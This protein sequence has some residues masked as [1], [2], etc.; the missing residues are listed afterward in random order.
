MVR[1][2]LLSGLLTVSDFSSR[3]DSDTSEAQLSGLRGPSRQ[4]WLANP[5]GETPPR[6]LRELGSTYYLALACQHFRL[7]FWGRVV[8][9]L[10]PNFKARAICPL[11]V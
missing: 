9:R 5:T 2:I 8:D 3:P 10:R 7:A 4:E 1:Y 6:A 11:F